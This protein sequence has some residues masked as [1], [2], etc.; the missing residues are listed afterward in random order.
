MAKTWLCWV[1]L[2]LGAS[3]TQVRVTRTLEDCLRGLLN[4]EY[5]RGLPYDSDARQAQQ[6]EL[7]SMVEQCVDP[8]REESPLGVITTLFELLRAD[9]QQFAIALGVE[10]GVARQRSAQPTEQTIMRK[11]YRRQA[12]DFWKCKQWKDPSRNLRVSI[13]PMSLVF[14]QTLLDTAIAGISVAEN[15]GRGID[16][17]VNT[18]E[19]TPSV[20]CYFVFN[21]TS[22]EYDVWASRAIMWYS[23]TMA[24]T[25]K[26]IPQLR[27]VFLRMLIFLY[28]NAVEGER[29]RRFDW[30]PAV[31]LSSIKVGGAQ[32]VEKKS[33]AAQSLARPETM[34]T[35]PLLRAV[36]LMHESPV[37]FFSDELKQRGI[38]TTVDCF[39]I[40][41]PSHHL[42]DLVAA[43][44]AALTGKTS[45]DPHIE[46]RQ[47]F[48]LLALNLT[49]P[50]VPKTIP[51]LTYHEISEMG[52]SVDSMLLSSLTEYAIVVAK[53][54]T[55]FAW[56]VAL[57]IKLN[58]PP[59]EAIKRAC[60]SFAI[61][62]MDMSTTFTGSI[63]NL[64]A[65]LLMFAALQ[66]APNDAW[67]HTL[68]SANLH[69]SETVKWLRM[70]WQADSIF[71]LRIPSHN[72][73]VEHSV[74]S[75]AVA[76]QSTPPAYDSSGDLLKRIPVVTSS[77]CS[78]LLL[79]LETWRH[80]A[81][82]SVFLPNT[83]IEVL[84]A[85]LHCHKIH[86]FS[87]VLREAKYAAGLLES[88]VDISEVGSAA[89]RLFGPLA[90][91]PVFVKFVKFA[92]QDV[93]AKVP[94]VA[95]ISTDQTTPSASS[96]SGQSLD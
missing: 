46:H 84:K 27:P 36:M 53:D 78:P 66:T 10:L 20:L 49:I 90:T 25:P 39:G 83:M 72:P 3:A 52:R 24:A 28:Q 69:Y 87:R 1:L 74:L 2:I 48:P 14:M 93:G 9:V 71:Q 13:P 17:C 63:K 96:A 67:A 35:Q 4:Q 58:V 79:A 34:W 62:E 19:T 40:T 5:C 73:T 68:I 47:L 64:L 82:F 16:R 50:S 59:S 8:A 89:N 80:E 85:L 11:L 37:R 81:P 60:N 56:L 30:L 65:D 22:E 12:A 23:S 92:V 21:D 31:V 6:L 44:K 54:A 26:H 42:L 41:V 18:E 7:F 86:M 45:Y 75:K 38:S 94:L 32:G 57:S 95:A 29:H 91:L 15:G 33:L 61:E 76:V 55:A 51:F 88:K 77:R 70:A 43:L